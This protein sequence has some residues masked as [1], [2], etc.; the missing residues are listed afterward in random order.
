MA[1]ESNSIV[2]H[3]TVEKKLNSFWKKSN[4]VLKTRGV[5]TNLQQ[6]GGFKSKDPLQLIIC[7]VSI[8]VALG[9]MLL[10]CYIIV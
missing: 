3:F 7:S 2:K 4:L 8:T 9:Q 6:G 1:R 5:V 10:Y